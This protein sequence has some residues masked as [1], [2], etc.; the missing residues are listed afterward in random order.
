MKQFILLV[1]FLFLIH[2]FQAQN[3]KVLLK[4]IGESYSGDCKKGKAHGQ[5]MAEGIDTYTGQ[6]K[7][8]RPD[9]EGVYLWSNGDSFEGIF[10]KGLKEGRGKMI[11]KTATLKDSIV[12]GFWKKDVYMGLYEKPYKKIDKSSN[13]AGINFTKRDNLVNKLRLYVREDQKLVDNPQIN[14]IIHHGQYQD[15][16]NQSDFVEL[17]NVSFPLKFKAFYGQEYIE[18]EIL[19]PGS[20]EVRMIVENINGLRN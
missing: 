12:S 4:S 1:S 19:Q 15:I 11:Y 9:G 2:D 3:C 16:R 17:T 14:I 18:V 13:V 8:G 20:W 5:G 10:K 6:F 7:K